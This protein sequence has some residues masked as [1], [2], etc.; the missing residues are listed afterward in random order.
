MAMVT[1]TDREVM[2]DRRHDAVR[3]VALSLG[4]ACCILLTT[5]AQAQEVTSSGRT[6]PA[7]RAPVAEADV[8]PLED[9]VPDVLFQPTLSTSLTYSDN[10]DSDARERS[11]WLF[12]VAPGLHVKRDGTRLRGSFNARWRNV[13]Y[14]RHSEENESFL[15]LD[16]RGEYEA[17]ADSLFFDFGARTTRENRSELMGRSSQ[18][19]LNI[20]ANDEV[21]DFYVGPRWQFRLPDATVGQLRY[22]QRWLSGSGDYDDRTVGV[23]DGML[24]NRVAWGPWGW[25]MGGQHER[26]DYDE[27][28][29]DT[30][31][32]EMAR[33]MLLYTVDTSL[34]LMGGLGYE[35]IEAGRLLNESDT[36]PFVGFEWQPSPRTHFS[37]MLEDR[38]FGTGYNASFVNRRP[39][40]TW[41]LLARRDINSNLDQFQGGA[42]EEQLYRAAWDSLGSTVTDPYER[43][44]EARRQAAQQLGSGIRN[45]SSGYELQRLLRASLSYTWPR[46][47]FGVS[48]ERRMRASLGSPSLYGIEDDLSVYDRI[49]GHTLSTSLSRR[50]TRQTSG[51]LGL[52]FDR[53]KG[54]GTSHET[55]DR[56]TFT[57][58]V[59]T[60]FSPSLSG[61][62]RY[63]HQKTDERGLN[64]EDYSENAVT[65]NVGLRF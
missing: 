30:V 27:S 15:A 57:V 46:T 65:A 4:V 20:S 23:A 22:R 39:R 32:R 24:M 21:R 35:S 40:L 3:A 19:E 50:L 49:D 34:Y 31:T 7:P 52:A 47:T 60:R 17:L 54:E 33:G 38:F 9:R 55:R 43:D 58:G 64:A 14:F 16:G 12:E 26:L 45:Y 8:A 10:I 2:R 28:S 13:V 36:F 48:A 59:T 6:L 5:A 53:S 62:L 56:T 61:S 42:L 41:S 51:A 1:V 44:A 29:L 18:D 63:R 25:A 11:D 37:A